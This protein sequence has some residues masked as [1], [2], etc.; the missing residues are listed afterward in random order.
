VNNNQFVLRK[1]LPSA[2]G[3]AMKT[4][5]AAEIP[6][7]FEATYSW[8]VNYFDDLSELA[9]IAFIQDETTREVFQAAILANPDPSTIPSV[10]TGVEPAFGSRVSFYPNPANH[11]LN[12]VLP[13]PS[14]GTIAVRVIDAFGREVVTTAFGKGDQGGVINT[15]TLAAGVYVVQLQTAKGTL[16]RKV[17]VAHD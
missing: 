14:Q 10:V 13:E 8:P 16:R 1:K 4:S 2:A 7:T 12:V 17:I 3:T 9:V 6:L 5:P 11:S 15:G